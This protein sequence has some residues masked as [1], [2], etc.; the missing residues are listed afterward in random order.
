MIDMNPRKRGGWNGPGI[1]C[2]VGSTRFMDSFHEAGWKLT[3]DGYIVLSVGVCKHAA[4]HGGEA[5]GQD[6]CDRLDELHLRKIDL[7]D[8]VMVL[9]VGGYIGFS[10]QREINYASATGKRIE[11]LEEPPAPSA[12]LG[13]SAVT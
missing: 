5:L 9:N 8:W 12:G 6:V 4:H 3:L 10:T 1:V 7:A 13:A 2:L 11:Y